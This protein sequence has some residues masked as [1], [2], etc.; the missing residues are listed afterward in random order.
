MIKV[1]SYADYHSHMILKVKISLFLERYF[2]INEKILT[3]CTMCLFLYIRLTNKIAQLLPIFASQM[4]KFI[5]NILTKG[6]IVLIAI[7]IIN[8][9]IDGV[10]FQPMASKVVIADFN[11]LNSLTEYVSEIVLG[12]KDAFPEFQKESSSSKSQ[13][14][15]HLSL[16]LFQHEN[17]V[18]KTSY[19]VKGTSF[20]VPLTEDYKF[21][22]FREINPPPPKA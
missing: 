7:Q 16:K 19:P 4:K 13:I 3:P 5:T 8:L 6:L 18:N 2:L 10:D 14:I 17:L 21:C 12:H 1:V 11:Y 15:K 20:I 9:S 22:Y